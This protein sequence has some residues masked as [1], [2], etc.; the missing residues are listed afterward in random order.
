MGQIHIF[1]RFSTFFSGESYG[2]PPFRGQVDGE[3][4]L[5]AERLA[6]LAPEPCFRHRW[7]AGTRGSDRDRFGA[8]FWGDFR[9]IFGGI[10][11][12]FW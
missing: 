3:V 12:I 6:E 8:W 4:T 2:P 11:E 5:A 7:D 1:P 9:V 10:F